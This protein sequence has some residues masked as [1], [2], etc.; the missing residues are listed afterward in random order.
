MILF[1]I[2]DSDY[3]RS[4]VNIAC[5]EAVFINWN[6]AEIKTLIWQHML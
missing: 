1:N 6:I 5:L 3:V 2:Y 4:C